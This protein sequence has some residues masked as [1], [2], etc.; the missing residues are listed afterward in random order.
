MQ[1]FSLFAFA[2]TRRALAQSASSRLRRIAFIGGDDDPLLWLAP[3]REHGWIEGRNFA[4]ERRPFDSP[5]GA[6]RVAREFVAENVDVIVTDGTNAA[7]AAKAATARIPIV[8]AAVGDPVDAGIVEAYARPGGNITGYAILSAEMAAKRAQLVKELVPSA[9]RV[10]V[11]MDPANGMYPLLRQRAEE[12]YRALAIVPTFNKSRAV[13]GVVVELS[14][15][16]LRVDAVEIDPDAD[17]KDAALLMRALTARGWPVVAMSRPMIDAGAVIAYDVDRRDHMR[18]VAAIIDKVLRGIAPASI[19][20]EQPSSF[21]LIVN[22][23]AA[24]AIG[25]T[26]P[27]S[28]LL[29]ADEVLQ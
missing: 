14:D 24:K 26:V 10:A 17:S 5:E 25:I 2:G 16:A 23:K 29:R 11:V 28:L 12:A 4:I 21:V 19:P 13:D 22:L 7:R 18:R 9:Q 1:A 20:V 27:Q 3:L 6:A 8:M 15:P